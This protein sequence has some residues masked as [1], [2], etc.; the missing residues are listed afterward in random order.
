MQDL[1]PN[2][3]RWL[4]ALESDEYPQ[5][6]NALNTGNGFCCLGVACEIFKTDSVEMGECSDGITYNDNWETAPRF[7]IEA[8]G[9]YGEL[10]EAAPCT[11]AN[12]LATLNDD[13]NR[14]FR[15]IA[16]I[17]KTEPGVYFKEAK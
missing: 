10:G 14:T 5:G 2:Q 7:V 3:Q 13:E 11:M 9:L 17:I 6:K 1:G 4:D 15:E 12:K 8:L 16:A